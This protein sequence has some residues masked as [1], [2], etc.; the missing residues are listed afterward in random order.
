VVLSDNVRV[1]SRDERRGGT[2]IWREHEGHLSGSQH[3]LIMDLVWMAEV[4]L[5][6]KMSSK[7]IQCEGVLELI[8]HPCVSVGL[9]GAKDNRIKLED[10]FHVHLYL[11]VM[12]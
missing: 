9:S 2:D 3:P 12:I 5:E 11:K 1:N 4:C 10:D 7:V 6:A 8:Y